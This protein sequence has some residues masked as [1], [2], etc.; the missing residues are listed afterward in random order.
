MYVDAVT[1]GISHWI[2]E[3]VQ[4][5]CEQF[6]NHNV[7]TTMSHYVCTGGCGG[8]SDSS[9]TCHA[10]GCIKEDQPLSECSCEDGMH[11]ELTDSIE[12]R[13]RND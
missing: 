3:L 5:Q 7:S 10:E 1:T 4:Y 12:E 9:G 8:E 2:V 13:T 11:D 6:T